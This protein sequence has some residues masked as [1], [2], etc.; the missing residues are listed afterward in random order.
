VKANVENGK[1]VRNCPFALFPTGI[2]K[3]RS[4]NGPSPRET[5]R[6]PRVKGI[7]LFGNTFQFLRDTSKLLDDSYRKH[8]SVFR[9][10]ALWLKY[11]VI[12]GFEAKRF[13]EDGLAEKY[14]SRQQIFDAVGKQLGSADF[15]LG[16]SGPRH[17]RF[18]RLLAAAYSREVASQF[19]PDFVQ[20]TREAVRTWS[21]G[22]I[23]RVMKTIKEIAFDQYCRAMCGRSLKEYYK[24]CCLVTEYNMNIGGRV[25]P[26]WMYKM[27][28]YQAARQRVLQLVTGM[29]LE[30]RNNPTGA[31]KTIM[32][33]L[34]TFRDK[35][36][37]ALDLDEV[38]CYSMYGFAGSISYMGRVIGFMLYEILKDSGLHRQLVEEV[39]HVFADGVK[40]IEDVRRME[41]LGA[42]YNETLRFH[43][44]SQGMPFYTEKDF[45]FEGKKICAGDLTVLSQVPMSFSD[46]HF[47][48]PHRFDHHRM[49]N[50]RNE[51]RSGGA[52]HPFGIGHRTCT[53]TGLV[54]LM[55]LTMVAVFLHE[56]E[57]QIRPEK[58]QLSLSVKPLPAPND[59]FKIKITKQRPGQD[60]TNVDR[61]RPEEQIVATY[62]GYDQPEVQEALKQGTSR[63]YRDGE[64]L[65]R[66]GEAA[67]NFYI[68]ETGTARVTKA[69]NG[70]EEEVAVL[71]AGEY[72]GEI[73]LLCQVPRMATVTAVG[74]P[75]EVIELSRPTFLDLVTRS[76][77]V[78]GEIAAM[79]R[80][81]IAQNRLREAIP[82]LQTSELARILPEFTSETRTAGELVIRQGE[83]ADR[84]YIVV[85]GEA[86]VSQRTPE[87][88]DREIARLTSGQYFGEIGLLQGCPRTAT[89]RISEFGTATL[90]STNRQGF[91]AM[92][93]ATGGIKGDLAQALLRRIPD[94]A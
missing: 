3:S 49:L 6:P 73:G 33:T 36:G 2:K 28:S 52:F 39:D 93:R 60:R 91:E 89:V 70:M 62:P 92:V 43:P 20:A 57:F 51:H 68:I 25:W 80:K 11:T 24:D 48:N 17:V 34:L 85:D 1:R 55:A 44:V 56:L 74:G 76:D 94:R 37:S 12:G 16:Q 19:V 41:L 61:L 4:D 32:D 90:L 50:P 84:F 35:D 79:V 38:V 58:Y 82:E 21:A 18:R 54:E 45:V 13:L 26:F 77:F 87:N 8:G 78:S 47:P 81:R 59:N 23:R 75:L 65:I 67:E 10:R 83:D 27:A 29:A 7:P 86:I 63:T 42:V 46:G 69:R 30:R 72:F 66:Q 5:P 40:S 53:A 31:Q 71:H 64:V 88:A 9:L 22:D 14:L 15:V